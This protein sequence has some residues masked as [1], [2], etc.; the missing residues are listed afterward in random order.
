MKPLGNVNHALSVVGKWIFHSNFLKSLM[1]SIE[2]LS[3]V[4]S[5]SKEDRLFAFFDTVFYA[6][7][8]D[9]PKVKDKVHI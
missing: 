8:Y 1:L 6:I 2:Y 5:F 7:R 4:F 3:L 9:N